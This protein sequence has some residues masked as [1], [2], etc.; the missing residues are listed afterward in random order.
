M[1]HAKKNINYKD[2]KTVVAGGE[3]RTGTRKLL[4]VM[5]MFYAW[6]SVVSWDYMFVRIHQTGH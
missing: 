5:E 1:G 4:E 6:T 2:S 3:G